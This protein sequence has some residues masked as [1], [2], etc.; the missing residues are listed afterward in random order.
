[1]PLD[2]IMEAE[3]FSDEEDGVFPDNWWPAVIFRDMRRQWRLGQGGVV[4]LD[5][6]T[7]PIFSRIRKVPQEK[8]EDVLDCLQIMEAAAIAEIN[9][10]KD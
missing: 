3:G 6:S 7:L 5:F 4:G 2:F 8:E 9:R 10:K 1:M